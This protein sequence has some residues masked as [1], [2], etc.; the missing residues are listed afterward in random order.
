MV[1]FAG[2][3]SRSFNVKPRNSHLLHLVA[4]IHGIQNILSRLSQ[5]TP[6]PTRVFHEGIMDIEAIVYL[7]LSGYVWKMV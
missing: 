7:E 3:E 6:Q 2:L 5:K 4:A 1:N